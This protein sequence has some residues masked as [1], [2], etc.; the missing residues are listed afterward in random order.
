MMEWMHSDMGGTPKRL[1]TAV[2][3]VRRPFFML[4]FLT[5]HLAFCTLAAAS[6]V[7]LG[8]RTPVACNGTIDLGDWDFERDGAVPLA[9]QWEFYWKA[10]VP[11]HNGAGPAAPGAVLIKVPGA[12]NDHLLSGGKLPGDGF[13]TYRLKVRLKPSGKPLALKFLDMA[14]AFRVYVNGTPLFSAGRPGKTAATSV[15]R[16]SP[17]VAV[18]GDADHLDIVVHVSNFHHRQGGMW[19]SV[20]LG[21][22][23]AL[24]ALRETRL[25]LDFFLLGSILIMGLYHIGLYWIRRDDKTSLSF[26]IFCVLMAA[27]LLSVG[28]AAILTLYPGLSYAALSR[29]IYLSFYACVPFFA[30]YINSMFP[31]ELNGRVVAAAQISGGVLCALVLAVPA[32]LYT[33]TMPYFQA[34]TVILFAYATIAVFFAMM[35]GR[36]WAR[37]FLLGFLVL[38]GATINDIL[39][40]RKI[41]DTGHFFH[42]GFFVFVF[43]QAFILSRRFSEAFSTVEQQGRALA[44]ANAA[45]RRELNHRKDAEREL[46]ENEKKYRDLFENGSDLL[47]IH[48]LDGNLLETNIHYKQEYGWRKEDLEGLNIRNVIPDRFKASYD[49]Y[50]QRILA[51]GFD[52][53]YLRARTNSGA[54]VVLEYRNRLIYDGAGHPEAVQA[55]AR[56]VTERVRAEKALRISEEKYKELVQHAPAGIYEFDME[57]LRFISVND[58]MCEYTGYS[59]SEFLALDP[60]AILSEDSRDTLSKLIEDV[61]NRKPKELSAEYKLVG[62]NKREFWVLS[63]ARFFYEDDVPRRAM[64]VVHDLT[65][66]RRAEAER[67]KLEIQLQNAKKLESIGTL[68]GGVAHDLNNI[69]SGIVG[70]P[71]LLLHDLAADSPYRAPLTAIK[72][73]GEKAAEIVQDLLTLARRGVNARKVISLNRVVGDFVS[74]PEYRKILANRENLRV[75]VDLADNAINIRGSEVHLSKTVMNLF[76]NAVDAMPAGGKIAISTASCY[77]DRAHSG[78]E[79]IPEG[80]YTTFEISDDGIGMNAS[81]LERIFEPFFTKKTMGRSGTGLGMSVVWGTV[82]D[83]GGFI[84]ITTEE[85]RGTTFALHFPT[86]RT[87][88]DLAEPVCIEDYLGKGET[89]LIVDDATEQR[90]LAQRMMMRLGYIADAADSGEAAVRMARQRA[91]DLLVLDMIMP[92]GIDGLQ[93]Y[94][95][96]LAFR[97]HQKAIIVSG[98]SE[99]DK[100]HQA[101]QLG[102]GSYVRK[103]YSL[104]KIGIAARAE[105]DRRAYSNR[106]KAIP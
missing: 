20:Q 89:V 98:F 48:D 4:F 9:G 40:T 53:G 102:A 79:V 5:W 58:V 65:G 41:V 25:S 31:G 73:S 3:F 82:K 78:F 10:F 34:F 38:Y 18:I 13:A 80:E 105:L 104:E 63:N 103:P 24:G 70:Y 100:V 50:L 71:D 26:G 106:R 101:Q 55:A 59:Q 1:P 83:H 32:R 8:R 45:Y 92:T 95:E 74:S 60:F 7:P 96:I 88:L 44:D 16:F 42:Y 86:S 69:L 47:C 21:T 19:E 2:L 23:A 68:A 77:I 81:D 72:N 39:Y 22:A 46:I 76:A 67:K 87:D 15:P 84:D 14:T 94:K 97:P 51:N 62:K 49:R 36:D 85:G 99:T 66:I 28:E 43:S 57:R 33:Y 35:R 90:D 54:E 91:Y 93:T 37:P 64:A 61:Y 11:P 29:I 6:G 12:W 75:T 52:S 56:D 30:M 27:R 17:G